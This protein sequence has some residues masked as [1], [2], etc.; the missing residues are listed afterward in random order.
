MAEACRQQ[1]ACPDVV[2][3]GAA[4]AITTGTARGLSFGPGA[5]LTLSCDAPAAL[6]WA[7]DY[8]GPTLACSEPG[9]GPALEV[10]S[11][12]EA[13][14]EL[15]AARPTDTSPEPIFAFD[16]SLYELPAWRREETLFAAD[17]RRSC[18]IALGPAGT[19]LCGDPADVR[20]RFTMALLIQE[21][22]ATQL[23][24]SVLEL[25]AAAVEVAGRSIVFLGPK[26]AGKTTLSFHLLRSGL[27]AS[28]ANDRVFAGPLDDG[29]HTW[30]MPSALKVRSGTEVEFPELR[31]GLPD[32]DRPFLYTPAELAG[33][34][35]A[36]PPQT[37]ELMLGPGQLAAL[38]GAERSASAP[39]GALVFPEIDPAASGW[40]VEPL[41]PREVGARVWANLFGNGARP[42]RAT[43]FEDAAGGRRTPPSELADRLAEAAPGFRVVLG[44]G[45]YDEPDFGSAFLAGVAPWA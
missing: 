28:V 39:L 3:I 26:R 15:A 2:A 10:A 25:H 41:A 29:A 23:R 43:V 33:P 24:Q 14:A 16:Q 18:V 37:E 22:I 31:G 32:I 21:L 35:D 9:P 38:L 4:R 7:L 19:L 1:I 12:A 30:G 42:R 11:S 20:W 40:S 27:C 36:G 6:A 5:E 17:D 34:P 44:R 45:A 13:F 8:F